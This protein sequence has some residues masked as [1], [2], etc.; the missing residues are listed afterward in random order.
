MDRRVSVHKGIRLRISIPEGP[1]VEADSIMMHLLAQR[2]G[3]EW[4]T[5]LRTD[6]GLV[7]ETQAVMLDDSVCEDPEDPEDPQ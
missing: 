6:D 4:H 1:I 3:A 7:I 5:V 2:C